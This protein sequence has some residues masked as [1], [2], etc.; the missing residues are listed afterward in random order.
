MISTGVV[1]YE[2]TLGGGR[3]LAL[4][5]VVFRT[6]GVPTTDVA[7]QVDVGGGVDEDRCL[8]AQLVPVVIPR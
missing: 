3:P 8:D 5:I 1:E 7:S 4:H 6:D 2:A